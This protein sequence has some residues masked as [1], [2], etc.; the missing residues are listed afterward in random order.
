[1][2]VQRSGK[3]A[4]PGLDAAFEGAKRGAVFVDRDNVRLGPEQVGQRQRE[5]PLPRSE[6]GPRTSATADAVLDQRD[7]IGVFQLFPAEHD[8][9]DE[10]K[11][12]RAD[13]R[14]DRLVDD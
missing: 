10:E 12:H 11:E 4:H 13:E 1:M 8:A 9:P 2:Q 5:R 6:V 14:D 7:V 3:V